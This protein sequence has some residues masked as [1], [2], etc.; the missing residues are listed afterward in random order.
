MAYLCNDCGNKSSKKFPQ[1][2][3]PAC[4]SFNIKST[5]TGTRQAIREKEPKTLLELVLMVLLWGLLIYGAWDK[6]VRK[7]E[8]VKAPP[9]RVQSQPAPDF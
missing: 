1:G 5:H 4:D 3:C 9:V 7:D 6:Y 8:P 2:K